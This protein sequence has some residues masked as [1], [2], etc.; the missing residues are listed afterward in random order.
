[1]I[2]IKLRVLRGVATLETLAL[3]LLGAPAIALADDQAETPPPSTATISETPE[4]P[5]TPSEVTV[6]GERSGNE[7]AFAR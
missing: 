7:A 6:Q 1:M 3:A 2:D 5:A 4:Q